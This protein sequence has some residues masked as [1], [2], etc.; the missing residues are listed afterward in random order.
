MQEM[1]SNYEPEITHVFEVEVL[2]TDL[3]YTHYQDIPAKTWYI[4]HNMGR[5]PGIQVLNSA[6]NVIYP[7]I[8]HTSVNTAELY[9]KA[10]MSGR[11]NC[12]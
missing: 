1:N 12:N 6:G 5:E 11:A 8:K 2:S 7:D 3:H 10:A 9:F 4:K